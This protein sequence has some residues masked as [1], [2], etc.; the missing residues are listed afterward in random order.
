MIEYWSESEKWNVVWVQ[1]GYKCLGCLLLH[2]H[3]SL[4]GVAPCHG[5]ASQGSMIQYH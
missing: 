5:P 3:G 4:G 1:N 2:S